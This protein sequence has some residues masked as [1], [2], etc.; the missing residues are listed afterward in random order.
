MVVTRVVQRLD[1]VR[2]DDADREVH[3][4]RESA[5]SLSAVVRNDEP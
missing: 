3:V 5:R 1:S 2:N 4:E